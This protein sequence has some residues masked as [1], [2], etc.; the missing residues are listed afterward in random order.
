MHFPGERAEGEKKRAQDVT[1]GSSRKTRPA[2]QREDPRGQKQREERIPLLG[3]Q[4]RTVPPRPPELPAAWDPALC[5]AGLL[6]RGREPCL[7]GGERRLL[8]RVEDGNK[9]C[10]A[11]SR[12][13]VPVYCHGVE[14]T[15][16]VR[17][18]ERQLWTCRGFE[19]GLGG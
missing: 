7:W 6:P 2:A 12:V 19:W 14:D 11:V 5:G 18:T 4:V 3:W 17:S 8:F 13:T 1:E 16:T 10:V 15:A 9:V